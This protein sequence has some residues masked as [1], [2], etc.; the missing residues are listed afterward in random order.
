MSIISDRRNGRSKGKRFYNSERS[1][2]QGTNACNVYGQPG[3]T[4]WSKHLSQSRSR[5]TA[6]RK[7]DPASSI[8]L[9]DQV[10]ST[11]PA[12]ARLPPKYASR[13]QITIYNLLANSF[14]RSRDSTGS[15]WVYAIAKC[16]TSCRKLRSTE[17]KA[18]II[19]PEPVSPLWDCVFGTP[20]RISGSAATNLDRGMTVSAPASSAAV[21][22]SVSTWAQ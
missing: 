15:V 1:R 19:Y 9:Q 22:R 2:K 3:D 5:A 21:A 8:G 11:I 20:V 12:E 17:R 10:H 13:S 7:W 16:S 4:T 14:L 18:G 6:P